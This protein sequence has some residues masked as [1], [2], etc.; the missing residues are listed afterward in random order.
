MA[1]PSVQVSYNDMEIKVFWDLDI[2]GTY[3]AFNLYWSFD[4]NMIGEAKVASNIPNSPD[5]NYSSKSVLYKFKREVIGAINTS[6]IYLILKGI[7]TI[8]VEDTVNIGA[9]KRIESLPEQ[10]QRYRSA[11]VL[12]YNYSTNTWKKVKVAS[13]GN[14][15]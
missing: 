8:G 4:K 11:Q 6:V 15:G 10:L 13:D 3:I 14:L 12:G 5:T 7:D 1:A 9:I 2:T